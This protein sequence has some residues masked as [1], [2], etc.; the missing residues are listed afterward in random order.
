MILCGLQYQTAR[1]QN[2][3]AILY[4][5]EAKL[6][7]RRSTGLL[8]GHAKTL[9]VPSVTH[10][11]GIKGGDVRQPRFQSIKRFSVCMQTLRNQQSTAS[12]AWCTSTT[13]AA[14]TTYTPF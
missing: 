9:E 8:I 12:T 6:K 1:Y 7:I 5:R 13:P 2:W 11:R 4:L 10:A 3:F 14:L